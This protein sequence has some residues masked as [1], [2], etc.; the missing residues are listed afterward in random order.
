MRAAEV[1][2]DRVAGVLRQVNATIRVVMGL[3]RE[4]RWTLDDTAGG[5]RWFGFE[6]ARSVADDVLLVPLPGHTRGL[7]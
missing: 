6:S 7:R 3:L 1:E 2:S 5:E 4:P